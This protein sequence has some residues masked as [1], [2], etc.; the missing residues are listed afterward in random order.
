MVSPL[1]PLCAELECGLTGCLWTSDLTIVA[2]AVRHAT[3][4]L[5]L[6]TGDGWRVAKK[7]PQAAAVRRKTERTW[8]VERAGNQLLLVKIQSPLLVSLPGSV[9]LWYN[10]MRMVVR[11]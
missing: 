7:T 2:Q 10:R 1:C 6:F 8:V 5:G 11:S 9:K 3:P 4:A